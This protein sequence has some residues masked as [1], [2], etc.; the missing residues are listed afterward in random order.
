MRF[1]PDAEQREFTRTLDALL[2]AADVPAAARAWA[3]AETGPGRA[4]WR[5]L[6]DCGLFALTV[7]EEQEGV[8]V[9][10]VELALACE[11]LGRHAVPGPYV[12]SLAAA[13]LCARLAG[14][15]TE[16]LGALL[17]GD[18]LATLGMPG[19]GPYLLDADA[20]DA[21]LVV[22]DGDPWSVRAAPGH[23]PVRPGLDAARRYA[24]PLPG[25]ARLAAGPA[26]RRAAAHAAA[27]ARLAT[28]AQALGV[29]R[30]LLDRTVAHVRGRTQFGAPIGAFQAV[31]HRLADTLIA[32]EF[33]RPLVLG[34]A[35]TMRPADLAAA[36]AAAGEAAWTAARTALHLHGALGYTAEF[37]LSLWLTKAR[38]LRTAWGTP[39]RC[40]ADV[41]AGTGPAGPDG[42]G[43]PDG[44]A[45]PDGP[46]GPDGPA[47]PD[48]PGGPGG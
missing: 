2:G 23:G 37:D 29:G 47:G 6:A 26:V 18:A 14:P 27:L 24:L 19:A 42:P 4:L 12:E 13:A 35:V 7:P 25:G 32:L 46:G 5:R 33:A 9:R 30:T 39:A 3:R 1:L 38:A 41:L 11:Q 34:A 16:L 48:G 21:L 8:G 17:K 36:K 45:G 31:K 15:G 40:R 20:A 22:A 28:A 44:P 43:G 10:P